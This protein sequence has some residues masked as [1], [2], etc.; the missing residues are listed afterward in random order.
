[1]NQGTGAREAHLATLQQQGIPYEPGY[2]RQLY[3]QDILNKY[4]NQFNPANFR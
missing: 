2:E 1:M 3:T 4:R